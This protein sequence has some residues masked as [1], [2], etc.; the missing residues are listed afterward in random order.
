M[1][2]DLRVSI[3]HLMIL[4]VHLEILLSG[5][6]VHETAIATTALLGAIHGVPLREAVAF[7]R[8]ALTTTQIKAHNC[9]QCLR[10]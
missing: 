7:Q 6:I 3:H 9:S 2:V 10:P 1:A 5:S 8:G 4:D